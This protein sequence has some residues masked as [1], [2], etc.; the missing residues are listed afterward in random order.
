MIESRDIGKAEDH[1]LSPPPYYAD[2]GQEMCE[3]DNPWPCNTL[4]LYREIERLK[5][6]NKVLQNT[7]KLVHATFDVFFDDRR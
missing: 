3:C 1:F 5:L 7:L 4:P 2:G 6:E